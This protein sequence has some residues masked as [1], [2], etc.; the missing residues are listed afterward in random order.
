[1]LSSIEM[2]LRA[3]VKLENLRMNCGIETAKA[4][5]ASAR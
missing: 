5:V 1:M 4:S 2:P 3:P